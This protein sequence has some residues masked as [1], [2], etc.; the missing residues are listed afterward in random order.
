MEAGRLF[1][2]C[3]TVLSVA[4]CTLAIAA[5]HG[6]AGEPVTVFAAAS[7]TDAMEAIGKGFEQ[8]TGN[9]IRFSFAASSTLARQIEAGAPADIYASADDRWMDYL[10]ACGLI[11]PGSRTS[12]IGNRL[13]LIAPASAAAAKIEITS[14]M[15]L[16]GLLGKDGWLAVGDPDHVPA[17]LYAR[18]SLQRLNLWTSAHNRLARADNVRAALAL[19]ARGEAALGIVYATDARISSNVEV[20]GAFP[21]SSHVPI[22]YPFAIIRGRHSADVDAFF[23][24][25]TG[26]KALAVFAGFGFTQ[27]KDA[28]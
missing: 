19:V 23:R 11:E 3:L 9:R 18:Q 26:P 21:E 5:P 1:R 24:Y 10:D 12:P 25:I 8:E 14:S 13:V 4:L 27:V 6:K 2:K 16:P 17:G 7:L 22:R 20:L 28:P 15:N